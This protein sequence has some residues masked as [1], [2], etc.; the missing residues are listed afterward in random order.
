QPIRFIRLM[1]IPEKIVNIPD[2]GP[3]EN[4]LATD[5]PIFF[6]KVFQ[7]LHFEIV[8]G[9]EVGVSSLASE[10]MMAEA[11]P[12]KPRHTQSG[13]GRNYRPVSLCILRTLAQADEILRFERIDAVSVSLQIV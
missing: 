8:P 10:R 6:L 12:V 5:A 3:R 2:P 13:S 9:R 1:R 11:I 4:S 7:Q